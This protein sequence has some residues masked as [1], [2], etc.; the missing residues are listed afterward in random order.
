MRR[1]AFT[2]LGF[3]TLALALAGCAG[4]E[5]R[6]ASSPV[7]G[8]G[9]APLPSTQTEGAAE[10]LVIGA[11]SCWMGG[12]WSDALGERDDQPANPSGEVNS[13]TTGIERRCDAVLQEVFGAVDLMQYRQLRAIE[14][15]VVDTLAMRVRQVADNDRADR[16]HAEQLV[17]L[18]RAVAD[19]QRENVLARGAA[20]DVK[21][22]EEHGGIGS[23]SER[24]SDKTY[25]ALFLRRT[26][27]IETLLSLDAGDLS[28]E[29]HAIGTLC[30]L[31]RL[32]IA[33]GLPEHLKLYAV[34]G[35]FAV[36]FGVQAPQVAGDPA[37]PVP[38]G[39][40]PRYLAAVA[41]ATGHAVPA[42]ATQPI[43]RES[44]AWVGVLQ[45]FADRLHAG[46]RA[47]SLGTSLPRVV[48]QVAERLDRESSALKALFE[49]KQR[50]PG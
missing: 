37:T 27:G 3:A 22:D 11:T 23:P 48:S 29:A 10:R 21:R 36:L 49:S 35:P 32:A 18:V 25:A 24:A 34:G 38:S 43:D 2:R 4:S 1:C 46:M 13:R 42:A 30:A 16:G 6:Q 19:A 26:T 31:D 17:R 45:A 7:S 47:L 9:P 5:P 41:G 44:L 15:R 39:T 33:R 50:A 12:L 40:W 8:P 14:P 20:D 28:P